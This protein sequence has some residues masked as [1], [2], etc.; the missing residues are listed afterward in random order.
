MVYCCFVV[1]NSKVCKGRLLRFS[2]NWMPCCAQSLSHVRLFATPRTG[3]SPPGSSAHGDSPGAFCPGFN[4]CV[5]SIAQ[6]YQLVV[7]DS[8]RPHGLQPTR[9]L[10]PWYFSGKNTGVGFHFLLQRIFPTQ[11]SNLCHEDSL[12]LSHL[13]SPILYLTRLKKISPNTDTITQLYYC[14]TWEELEIWAGTL[15]VSPWPEVQPC[16]TWCLLY[17][18]LPWWLRG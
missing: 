6:L 13:G 9:F 7:S 15:V 17:F 1:L 10:C 16:L 18:R 14:Y 5:C 2:Y 8:L 12:P 4:T 3:C 11:E